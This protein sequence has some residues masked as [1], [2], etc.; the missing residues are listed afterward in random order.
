MAKTS[1]GWFNF[2]VDLSAFRSR[3]YRLYFAG[4][5]LSMTGSFM[6]QVAVLW[7]IYKVTD[8]ALLLGIAGF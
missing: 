5:S 8:S 2:N 4:Q 3:N 1:M 7:L 6:T